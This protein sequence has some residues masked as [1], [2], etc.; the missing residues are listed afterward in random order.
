M[1]G[2]VRAAF[3][4]LFAWLM[5]WLTSGASMRAVEQSSAAGESFQQPAVA[6]DAAAKSTDTPGAAIKLQATK[7][8]AQAPQNPGNDGAHS[9]PFEKLLTQ[10]IS[11]KKFV[12]V[13]IIVAFIQGRRM[14]RKLEEEKAREAREAED[15]NRH[16]AFKKTH[17]WRY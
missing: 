11:M 5:I 15:A 6:G 9:G 2:K 1:H 12:W 3:R 10:L 14:L 7:A 13:A 4:L 8:L 17:D 16:E